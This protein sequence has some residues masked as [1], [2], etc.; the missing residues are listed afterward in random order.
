MCIL[1]RIP[2][3]RRTRTRKNNKEQQ[4]C[5]VTAVSLPSPLRH[6]SISISLVALFFH[7]RARKSSLKTCRLP[8]ESFP[9]GNVRPNDTL[10]E[11]LLYESKGFPLPA[12]PRSAPCAPIGIAST[13]SR[14]FYVISKPVTTPSLWDSNS[15]SGT[16]PA[17]RKGIADAIQVPP[18]IE[19]LPLSLHLR[20]HQSAHPARGIG[21]QWS[22]SISCSAYPPE[23]FGADGLD[24]AIQGPRVSLC[25]AGPLSVQPCANH[26]QRV[27]CRSDN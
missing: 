8:P 13:S 18:R 25:H 12:H 16:G 6:R 15:R 7:M 14:K 22:Y 3:R 4:Q 26:V 24:G 10:E 2:P 5:P 11:H 21:L 9:G 1:A 23:P 19:R 20:A 17:A 27:H